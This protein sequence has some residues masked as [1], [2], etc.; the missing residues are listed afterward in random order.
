MT[1]TRAIRNLPEPATGTPRVL[2]VDDFALRRGRVY[3]SILIDIT[4]GRPVEVLTDRTAD[5][6]AAWLRA[7]PGVEIV[8]R[9]RAGAYAEGIARGA[10]EAIQVADRWHLWRN[11]GDAV[12]RAVAR[13]R[14]HLHVLNEK[15]QVSEASPARRTSRFPEGRN[16]R[17]AVRT[18]QRHTAVHALLT[19]GRT[20]MQIADEL[21]LSRNTIRR[22]ARAADPDL[23]LVHGG[24]GK[25]TK[26]LQA[27]DAYLRTRWDQGCTNAQ[28]LHAELRERG[29]SGA[30]ITV[31]QYLQPWRTRRPAPQGPRPPTVRQATAWFLSNPAHLDPG[32][33][34]RLDI[35]CNASPQLAVLRDR[36]RE[37]AEMM[38]HR[39]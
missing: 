38:V 25:R 7:H 33:Q 10:P 27:Y 12:E 17:V 20:I 6:L 31:R 11:L 39:Q 14:R 34:R 21:Q 8:C 37:F 4:T 36:V 9:D 24:T 28:R 5:T 35:L 2:G 23:L 16:D 13:H 19:Q 22:F 26:D 1:L 29:Y 18:R 30:L 15:A 32:D 3:G